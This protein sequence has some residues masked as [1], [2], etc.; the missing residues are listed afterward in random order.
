MSLVAYRFGLVEVWISNIFF[1]FSTAPACRKQQEI[2]KIRHVQIGELPRTLEPSALSR[3][4][5][6]LEPSTHSLTNHGALWCL[7]SEDLCYAPIILKVKYLTFFIRGKRMTLLPRG[8]FTEAMFHSRA[9]FSLLVFNSAGLSGALLS[10]KT[11][12]HEPEGKNKNM[13]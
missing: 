5:T 3:Q 13:Y 7:N 2:F 6:H 10:R 1:I 4:L 8:G 11:S 9:G 12:F